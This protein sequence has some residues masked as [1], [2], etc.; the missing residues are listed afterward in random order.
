MGACFADRVNALASAHEQDG[1]TIGGNAFQLVLRQFRFRQ[2]WD[3]IFRRRMVGAVVNAEPLFVY[4]VA[5]QIG[6]DG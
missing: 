4:Q 2:H 3:K 5:A 6:R 1:H